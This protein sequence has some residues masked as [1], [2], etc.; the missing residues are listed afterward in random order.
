MAKSYTKHT[1]NFSISAECPVVNGGAQTSFDNFKL[2][3]NF[4]DASPSMD[5]A[6]YIP[7]ANGSYI[8]IVNS[9]KGGVLKFASVST[10]DDP[11]N[12]IIAYATEMLNSGSANGA[13]ITI[14]I[15]VK[16]GVKIRTFYDCFP[17]KPIPIK[18]QGNDEP[19]YDQ[20]FVYGD[21]SAS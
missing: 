15:P 2:E 14:A 20:E 8:M 18:L 21:W 17:N 6:K 1:G 11:T 10:S 16:N 3:E 7:L 5:N 12:D 19:T 9:V 4:V 13:T